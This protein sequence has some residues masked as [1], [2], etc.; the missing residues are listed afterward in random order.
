MGLLKQ[1][2][3]KQHLE[4]NTLKEVMAKQETECKKLEEGNTDMKTQVEK[5]KKANETLV[6]QHK[7]AL[8]LLK[9]KN[10]TILELQTT[11]H[12][13]TMKKGQDLESIFDE[14]DVELRTLNKNKSKRAAVADKS[15]KHSKGPTDE[16]LATELLKSRK[17]KIKVE[18]E[19]ADDFQESEQ[20]EEE[21]KCR[22]CPK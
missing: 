18:K 5:S 8:S 22:Y 2:V 15:E 10:E 17:I 11:K 6:Q 13:E 19:D 16:E 14:I 12:K 20:T 3:M 7:K 4:I 1:A 21:A 9:Q